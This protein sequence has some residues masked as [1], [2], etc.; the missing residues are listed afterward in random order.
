MAL[1]DAEDDLVDWLDDHGMPDAYDLAST[2]AAAA[3]T[4]TGATE[5]PA[6]STHR[7]A[8][9]PRVDRRHAGD[10][11][12][13]RRAAGGHR[14]RLRAVGA[15]RSYTQMDRATL[16]PVD[17]VE[18]LESTLGSCFTT[19][20]ARGSR[21]S[22]STPTTCRASRPTPASST[23]VDDLIDNAVD[24]MDGTGRLR[25]TVRAEADAIEV[26]IA[27]TGTGL[28]RRGGRPRLRRL[29]Q[30]RT[31]ARAP[32]SAS[33]SPAASSSSATPG[34]SSW[35]AR[36]TR[37]WPGSASPA[38]P[39]GERRR[40]AGRPRNHHRRVVSRPGRRLL[41]LTD[42]GKR[43]AGRGPEILPFAHEHLDGAAEVLAAR[44]RK[45][46]AAEP[47]LSAAYE[48]PAATRELAVAA[49]GADEA[50]GSVAIDGSR[51]VGYLLGAPKGDLWGR[52]I[53][54]EAAGH[55][56]VEPEMARDPVRRGRDALARREPHGAL[57][58]AAV[59][60]HRTGAGLVPPGLRLAAHACDPRAG[61]GRSA[62][63]G[64]RR[65]PAATV[66]YLAGPARHGADRPPGALA[67]LLRR[68]ARRL[69]G[70]GGR[71]GG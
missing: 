9:R 10:G 50:S 5:P 39:L 48:D 71:L 4:R 65:T 66:R 22:A 28:T 46:R 52:N 61:A 6:C 55:A 16:Q 15:V 45:H 54:V 62:A 34:P 68:A 30:T 40:P 14:T 21:W 35:S 13:P 23:G 37:P 18:G 53:W 27:D 38:G 24:A 26:E 25:V 31:S 8:A 17:V 33:T 32:A 1:S 51:V 36:A 19:R 2:L 42:E 59:A 47:L 29:L 11:H 67:D 70:A 44:H 60:R 49:Y 12:A 56:V 57:R 20:P 58:T 43:P 64:A 69:R 41:R 7:P 63:R 3:S